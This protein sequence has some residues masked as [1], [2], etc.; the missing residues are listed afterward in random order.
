MWSGLAPLF[1][2]DPNAKEKRKKGRKKEGRKKERNE[3]RKKRK[4]GRKKKTFFLFLVATAKRRSER[5]ARHSLARH[6]TS[7]HGMARHGTAR[8]GTAG[9]GTAG[10]GTALHSPRLAPALRG[11]ASSPSPCEAFSDE[12]VLEGKMSKGTINLSAPLAGIFY[13]WGV[14][15]GKIL[16]INIYIKKKIQR[17]N[18]RPMGESFELDNSREI[19]GR[20]HE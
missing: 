6:S 12:T 3:G 16:Y 18:H 5:P 17:K 1:P 20:G 2:G 19:G 4:E 14:R 13:C 11:R 7:R 9:H 15:E 10:H 8:Q